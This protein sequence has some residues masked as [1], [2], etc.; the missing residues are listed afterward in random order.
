MFSKDFI[1]E[2]GKRETKYWAK[3]VFFGITTVI[4]IEQMVNNVY[5]CGRHGGAR[6][7][8]IETNIA[9]EDKQKEE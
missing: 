6:I 2:C 8:A 9:E 7:L 5:K 3:A 1:T 4:S